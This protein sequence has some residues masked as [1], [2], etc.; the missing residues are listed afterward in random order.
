M[1]SDAAAAEKCSRRS[2]RAAKWPRASAASHR[3]LS[4]EEKALYDELEKENA[5]PPIPESIRNPRAGQDRPCA[6]EMPSG[7]RNVPPITPTP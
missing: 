6:T 4:D 3:G 7:Q 2:R 5:P 1:A